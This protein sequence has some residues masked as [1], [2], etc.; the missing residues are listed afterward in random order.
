MIMRLRIGGHCPGG[1]I[2]L[3]ACDMFPVVSSPQII[4][5]VDETRA[6]FDNP[7][8]PRPVRVYLWEPLVPSVDGMTRLILL[9][10]GTGASGR[11][12][13]WLAEPLAQVGFLV[14]AVDHHG[15]NWVDGYAAPGFIF[16][17]E[18]PADLRHGVPSSGC[19]APPRPTRSAV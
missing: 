18:R 10:Y 7:A 14:A 13:A 9:S 3:L 8:N 15:N 19:G 11:D 17:W 6:S 16:V 4:E 5:A 2:V 12:L 1:T